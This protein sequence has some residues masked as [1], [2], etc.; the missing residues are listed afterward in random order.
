[1]DN[2]V[3]AI[4]SCLRGPADIG[5]E[6]L[7]ISDDDRL[8]WGEFFAFFA[9]AIGVRLRTAPASPSAQRSKWPGRFLWDSTARWGSSVRQILSSHEFKELG[10]RILDTDPIGR[11]P[12]QLLESS[13]RLRNWVRKRLRMQEATVYRRA[14]GD[15]SDVF[16][17]H[18][19]P[20][21][22]SIEK[23]RRMLGYC[24]LV[25]RQEAL[26]RTLDWLRYANMA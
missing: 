5:G 9:E 22:A 23:A 11:W 3:E 8:T 2:L 15:P 21:E 12:R 14:D 20:A 24:P 19:R 1:V 4:S 25:T 13:P 6:V 17:F 16:R 26:Q 10:R 7:L 18:S